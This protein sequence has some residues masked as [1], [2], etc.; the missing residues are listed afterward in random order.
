MKVF[1]NY[2]DSRWKSYNINFQK[3]ADI[4]GGNN[5][6][7]VS[8]ILTNDKKI[9]NL[10][11][12][13]RGINKPTNVLSFETG[14]S[15][16]LGDIFI[17]IETVKREAKEQNKSFKYH[18]IHM[19]VHG[20]LHLKGFD[21]LNDTDAKKMEKMEIKVLNKLKI[22]NPYTENKKE[23]W[24]KNMINKIDN[25]KF[26]RSAVL[27]LCGVLSAIGFAPFN[28]W[29]L[30]IVGIG[31]A[32]YLMVHNLNRNKSNKFWTSFFRI[33]P[34]SAAYAVGMFWWVVNSIYVVPELMAQFAIWTIPALVGIAIFGGFIFAIPFVI[35]LCMR[36]NHAHRAFLFASI[37]TVVLWL[38][39]WLFTGFPWNPISNIT[40]PFPMLSNS[41]SLWGALGLTFI[42]IGLISSFVD[43][44]INRKSKANFLQFVIFLLLITTGI[45][46]GYKN[47]KESKINNF[48][49][50][51]I[52][53]I[54]QPGKSAVE[55]ATYS[56][57]QA[58]ANADENINNLIK[59]AYTDDKD[60]DMFV[61]PETTYPYLIVDNK[62]DFAKK[63][64]VKTIIGATYYK[65][66][67]F[68]N[69]LLIAS[70]D[71]K[72]EKVYSKSHLVP[73]GE[74]RPL[75]DIIPTPGQLTSG[76]GPEMIKTNLEG[77]ELSF[78]PAICYEIIFSDSL[79]SKGDNPQL[80]INITNDNWFG[81][82]PGTH[83]HLDMVRRY[84]I[85]SGMP[86]VRSNYSGISAFIASDGTVESYLPIGVAGSLDGKIG[87]HHMTVYRKIGRDNFMIIILMFSIICSIYISGFQ[88]KD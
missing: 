10:N 29:F 24:F 44:I 65:Y 11:H 43:L 52:I 73:F 5:N 46:F 32:Y 8:I 79:I 22:E 66:G 2:D 38:R 83:Q 75:G 37:W 68:Y 71:G 31:V 78:A 55:K 57:A 39:E 9:K 7:E 56:R 27:F 33:L 13:Y 30:N 28:L 76:N 64:G 3:I 23:S 59:L 63:L 21:H 14:D 34:F 47:I 15:E 1:V 50:A 82:T 12:E 26:I 77:R 60:I 17:S 45:L 72:I 25:N 49:S 35:I 70:P 41:M 74:Y 61:F 69:S 67:K 53:R 54:V 58:I 81:N 4:I 87:G 40:M 62:L 6:S 48:E 85:E 36:H 84:A 88:K 51:P 80:I 42:I 86:I 20:I 16:L 19:V 18:A